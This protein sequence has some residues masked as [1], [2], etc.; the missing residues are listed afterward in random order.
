MNTPV[1]TVPNPR[2]WWAL[3]VLALT[4]LVV[5]LDGTIVNIAL[6]QA[7][8]E[9]D[10]SDALRG[11]VV[12]AYALVFGSLLLLGGRIADTWGRKRAFMVGM[13]GFGLASYTPSPWR[14][15]GGGASTRSD[16]LLLG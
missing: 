13:V 4:Q 11:W 3:F 16:F 9:L 5:V 10:M 8:Q 7:Q 1:P 12:T 2:R 6:P 15:R 14:N